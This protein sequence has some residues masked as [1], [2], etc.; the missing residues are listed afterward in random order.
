MKVDDEFDVLTQQCLEVVF[1]AILIILE[2]QCS[3]QLPGGKYWNPTENVQNLASKVPLTNKAS[4]SDFALLDL[5]IRTKPNAKV[6]TIQALTM[7][8]RNATDVWIDGKTEEEK[9]VMF[10]KARK[11]VPEMRKRYD[12][13]KRKLEEEKSERLKAK[14]KELV[15]KEEKAATRKAN[16]VNNL[17]S[18][19]QRA[20]LN[21]EEAAEEIG[22]VDVKDRALVLEY[23]LDFY[24][25]CLDVKCENK[26][27]N[28][29]Q[30]VDGKRVK[31]TWEQRWE[32]LKKV[33]KFMMSAKAPAKECSN[34]VKSKGERDELVDKH[35]EEL[36][37][38]LKEARLKKVIIQ[39]RSSIF[40]KLL[41]NPGDVVGK[42]LQY[43]VKEEG[44]DKEYWSRAK[45]LNI[46]KLHN[47]AKQI[48]FTVQY[49][50][51]KDDEFY[52][53][54]VLGDFDKNCV[55]FL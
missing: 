46:A 9:K 26:L 15:E 25:Y 22:N 14:Q 4:E 29:T 36:T 8:C 20:W 53:M 28:R 11:L 45:V 38:K 17:L 48:E 13:R 32:N 55:I 18:L 1:H 51:D 5:F 27:Y 3:D 40:L 42:Y 37:E 39:Q 44:C 35:K 10:D 34:T 2:R 50:D 19:K 54:P 12:E 52:D 23:Q 16:A 24:K 47:N 21:E 30:V 41:E 43:K 33:M 7:W 49:E 6:Q 31:L